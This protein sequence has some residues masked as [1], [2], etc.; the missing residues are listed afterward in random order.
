M[1]NQMEFDT[2]GLRSGKSGRDLQGENDGNLYLGVLIFKNNQHN[3]NWIDICC[4]GK[5]Y[6]NFKPNL[7]EKFFQFS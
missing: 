7:S 2:I 3:F 4:F 1:K 6:Q 5:I